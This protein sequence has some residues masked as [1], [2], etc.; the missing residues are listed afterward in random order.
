MK[1]LALAALALSS[2]FMISCGGEEKKDDKKKVNKEVNKDE[3]NGDLTEAPVKV[4]LVEMDLSQYGYAATI[5]VPDD[6]VFEKGEFNDL[7]KNADGTFAVAI[8][9]LDWTKDEAM[10]EAKKN[11]INKLK[12]VLEETETGYWIQTEVMR[13]DD[14]HMWLSVNDGAEAPIIFENDNGGRPT[15]ATSAVMWNALKSV[16]VKS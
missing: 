8:Q 9:R 5:E 2:L 16:K 14:F 11:D 13:K 12:E 6:V 4:S 1:K 3:E 7:L 10:A 15:K